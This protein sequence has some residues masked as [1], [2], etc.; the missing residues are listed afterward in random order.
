MKL[1]K[2]KRKKAER[3]AEPMALVVCGMDSTLIDLDRSKLVVV[4]LSCKAF[5]YLSVNRNLTMSWDL[6][7]DQD[8]DLI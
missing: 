5:G 8:I 2:P 7:F 3:K 4:I 1:P 6:T